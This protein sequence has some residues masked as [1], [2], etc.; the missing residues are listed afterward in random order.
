MFP[1]IDTK[2]P[3]KGGVSNTNPIYRGPQIT[4]PWT[5]P[6]F[7]YPTSLF[8]T[9]AELKAH[10]NLLELGFQKQSE[11]L[12]RHEHWPSV[13]QKISA[14]RIP[15]FNNE[16]VAE[17]ANLVEKIRLCWFNSESGLGKASFENMY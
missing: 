7:E 9:N 2:T 8:L 15:Y 3:K 11:I 14:A 5:G 10:V 13:L 12:A 1:D 16:K 17:M 4:V 6:V